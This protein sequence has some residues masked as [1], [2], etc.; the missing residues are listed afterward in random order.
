MAR[1]R[2]DLLVAL[3]VV[4]RI[5]KDVMLAEFED[6]VRSEE[7][8]CQRVE[9]MLRQLNAK[10]PKS[11]GVNAVSVADLGEDFAEYCNSCRIEVSA[12]NGTQLI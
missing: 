2:H 8:N 12:L 10:D 9:G 3:R 1:Y 11:K 5:E 4:N 6:W 7:Q